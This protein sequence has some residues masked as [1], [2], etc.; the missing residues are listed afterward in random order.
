MRKLIVMLLPVVAL[1]GNGNTSIE[2]FL[3]TRPPSYQD[4]VDF[5]RNPFSRKGITVEN[6]N[7]I[8]DL[9]SIDA[10][11]SAQAARAWLFPLIDSSK[12]LFL[13]TQ[14]PGEFAIILGDGTVLRTGETAEETDFKVTVGVCDDGGLNFTVIGKSNVGATAE[15]RYEGTAWRDR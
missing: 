4:M 15:I 12:G 5:A 11:K 8:A 6:V 3:E 2:P 14:L 1:A 10:E 7:V 9:V 13:P